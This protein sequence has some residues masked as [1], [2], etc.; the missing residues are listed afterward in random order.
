MNEGRGVISLENSSDGDRN[1]SLVCLE[2]LFNLL[3]P[4]VCDL[5][6]VDDVRGTAVLT[7]IRAK[8][9]NI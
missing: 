1:K 3:R 7:T 6:C 2:F 8:G 5:P 4:A 9:N